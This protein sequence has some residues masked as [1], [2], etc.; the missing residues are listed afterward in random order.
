[1]TSIDQLIKR[2]RSG[3]RPIVI[4]SHRRSGTHLT[5]DLIRK[6]FEGST[7]PMRPFA[8]LTTLYLSMDKL[9]PGHHAPMPAEAAVDKLATAKHLVMKTHA[10]PDADGRLPEF[11][12]N[13]PLIQAMIDHAFK[14]NVVR[15]GRNVLSSQHLYEQGYNPDARLPTSDFLRT[16]FQGEPR[17]AFWAGHATS[18]KHTP[19]V[20]TVTF[21]DIIRSTDDVLTRIGEHLGIEPRRT[22]PLLP[23][24]QPI[25]KLARAMNRALARGET[26]A[27]EGRPS[28]GVAPVKW[29]AAWS[30][31]DR[32][33]FD[34][35][36]GDTLIEL[37]YEPDHSWARDA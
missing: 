13:E 37:G 26:T 35:H 20:L 34:E 29:R 32:R 16:S 36:A 4:L 9:R 28:K 21:E 11:E 10:R 18:W 33:H 24:K 2:V 5:I 30:A 23:M 7:P 6:Q 17:P 27:I 12:D 25:S 31:A 14:I 22:R 1:M 19:D 8:S 15:D 3:P